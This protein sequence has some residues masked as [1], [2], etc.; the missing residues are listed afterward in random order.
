M[1]ALHLLEAQEEVH[2]RLGDRERD[3]A[4]LL[5]E[6]PLKLVLA[7]EQGDSLLH[8]VVDKLLVPRVGVLG[9]GGRDGGQG[10]L[11]HELVTGALCS[12]QGGKG[13]TSCHSSYLEMSLTPSLPP[14]LSLSLTSQAP[15]S[16][17]VPHLRNTSLYNPSMLAFLKNC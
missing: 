3:K 13:D 2:E 16:L 6:V 14:P 12:S 7:D 15:A 17:L 4:Q 8:Q 10:L 9:H 1:G 11:L 5:G